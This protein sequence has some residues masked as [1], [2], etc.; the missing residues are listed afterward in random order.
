VSASSEPFADTADRQNVHC[1]HADRCAGCP[2]IDLTYS[3][4]LAFKRERVAQAMSRYPSLEPIRTPPVAPAQPIVGYRTRAKL[5]VAPGG[6]LG[7]YA[8]GGGH[9]VVDIPRCRVLAPALARVAAALRRLAVESTEGPLAPH[10]PSNPANLGWLRAVDLREVCDGAA[11]QVLVTLVVLRTQVSSLEQLRL[12][13]QQLMDAAP[14]VVGVAVNFH[15]G[16]GPQI[17]GSETMPIAGVAHAP[18]RVGASLHLATF[19][20]FVQVHRGQASRLHAILSEGLGVTA[21]RERGERLRVLD[22]YGGSGAIALGLASAGASVRLIESFEPSV[23]QARAAAE[24]LE[25]DLQAECADVSSALRRIADR[26]ECF[27]AA[28]VN[29]PRRGASPAAREWLARAQ[30]KCI[31]YVSCNP[32]TLAR[33]LDHLGRLGYTTTSLQPLDMIPLTE[34]VEVLALLTR[35]TIPTPRIA[36]EDDDVLVVDKG[37]HEPT[38]PQGEYA[39]SLL[40]RV[41]RIAGA[42]QAVPLQR[43]D[44]G[45]SGLAVFARRAAQVAAWAKVLGA[46]TTR[47]V[48][49]AAVR[50][51]IPNKGAI[52]RKLREE[53]KLYAARTRYRR[54]AVAGGHSIVRVVPDQGRTHQI[55][56]H[57]AA[58]GYPVLG[59]SR[60]GHEATNRYF[61]EKNGLDRA[62]LHCVRLE[63]DPRDG[64]VR[65]VLESPLPGDLR[66]VVERTSGSET[67]RFLD[68]KNALGAL[69]MSIPPPGADDMVEHDGDALEIDV[70]TPSI[71][72][73]IARDEEQEKDEA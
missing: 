39:G 19:G 5:V 34:E 37:P 47:K 17:L 35:A 68:H 9:H 14:E 43:L 46:P 72:P 73:E 16:D 58:I 8:K 27:D 50:G 40:A 22:L 23:A 36:Y 59:D 51:V 32:E 71:R 48:Y 12:A 2:T 4:Q 30:P 25:V 11:A 49:V 28:V 3:D 6:A 20:S 15:D 69:G 56:R 31:A 26:G 60:Y 42:E 45:T 63:F 13:A 54:L 57:L 62:F 66:A 18:D 24:R 55:R 44:V 10:D 64:G 33:D 7:L 65:Q 38:T 53:G 61:E 70:R 21:A 41:R 1:D 52:C 29:P 67:L